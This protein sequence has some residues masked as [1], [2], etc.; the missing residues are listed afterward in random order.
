MA[1]TNVGGPPGIG[2][3]GTHRLHHA[4]EDGGF[5]LGDLAGLL[6]HAG[7]SE[8]SEQ[9]VDDRVDQADIH[10]GQAR[11]IDRRHFPRRDIV[12]VRHNVA[13]ELAKQHPLHRD[14]AELGDRAKP[15][16]EAKAGTPGEEL[17]QCREPLHL[18]RADRVLRAKLHRHDVANVVGRRSRRRLHKE[19]INRALIEFGGLHVADGSSFKY[20]AK[21]ATGGPF[22]RKPPKRTVIS[23]R[24]EPTDAGAQQKVLWELPV[25]D[26]CYAFAEA[27]GS[28]GTLPNS[29]ARKASNT[30]RIWVAL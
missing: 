4:I 22:S 3:L 2:K 20:S 18:A 26:D 21:D 19:S 16:A 12:F 30:V 10:V 5:N 25:S 23:R 29:M 13:E 14:E 8:T 24:V 1:N 17:H 15:R 27:F 9:K 7:G 28:P 11:R 6:P